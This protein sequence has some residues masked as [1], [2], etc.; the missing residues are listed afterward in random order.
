MG[1]LFD[2][3]STQ[4]SNVEKAKGVDV[5]N[6]YNQQPQQPMMFSTN[7]NPGLGGMTGTSDLFGGM[8][9]TNTSNTSS[10]DLL[11]G[12][13]FGGSNTFPQQSNP[14]SGFGQTTTPVLNTASAGNSNQVT[15]K[16]FEDSN[17]E[18]TFN[19]TKESPDTTAVNTLFSNKSSSQITDLVF[20]AAVLKH[21]KLSMNAISSNKIPP[22]SNGT[23]T[24]TMKI[25]N[26]LQGTK[27]IIMKLKIIYN[28]NG[29]TV[30]KELTL[31]DFPQT[32]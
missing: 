16:A 31:N 29:Q 8:S 10:T 21:L 19:C 30:T 11:G 24:Q 4:T 23:V 20:Q 18:I 7:M 32:Y 9:F 25:V 6:L 14:M 5:L 22:N 12:L 13:N 2:V 28:L 26:T 27:G 3:F 17:L 1:D 15:I